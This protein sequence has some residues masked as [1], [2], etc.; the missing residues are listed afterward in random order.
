VTVDVSG[1]L[2]CVHTQI[3]QSLPVCVDAVIVPLC[4][5]ACTYALVKVLVLHFVHTNACFSLHIVL[6]VDVVIMLICVCTLVV[7]QSTFNSDDT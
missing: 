7:S 1:L 2:V 5:F 4:I 3:V 6:A